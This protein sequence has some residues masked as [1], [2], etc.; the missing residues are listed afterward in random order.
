MRR[1]IGFVICCFK[2]HKGARIDYDDPFFA[3]YI[4]ETSLHTYVHPCERCGLV[5]WGTY[6]L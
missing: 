5:Y 4:T 2:G 6:E 1:L 3:E